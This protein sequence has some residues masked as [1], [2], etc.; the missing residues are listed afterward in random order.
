V[1]KKIVVAVQWAGSSST[2]DFEFAW[3]TRMNTMR[4]RRRGRLT[5][6][7]LAVDCLDARELKRSSVFRDGWVTLPMVSL[8]WPGVAKMRVARYLIQ[9]EFEDLAVPQQIRV[10]W[11]RCHF[12]GARPWLHCSFCQ[13]RV[14][15]MFKG[16][17]GFFC[18]ACIGN[19]IYESQRRSAKARTYLKAY[20]LRQRLGGSRPVLDPIP[21]RPYRMKRRTYGRLCARIQLLERPLVRSRAVRRA[22][23]WIRPLAY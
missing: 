5:V 4:N 23:K 8:R 19:P 11:T 18:R 20:R 14:A 16:M 1:S 17:G 22:P 6:E 21:E 9:L 12:G 2:T 13:R 15:R 10:S 7:K 3:D